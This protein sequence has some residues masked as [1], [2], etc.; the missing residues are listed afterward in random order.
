MNPFVVTAV[1]A[2][3]H[4]DAGPPPGDGP[5]DDGE[6]QAGADRGEHTSANGQSTSNGQS[7]RPGARPTFHYK[8]GWQERIPAEI[9]GHDQWVLWRYELDAKRRWTKVPYRAHQP[10]SKAST[11]DPQTWNPFEFAVNAFLE[12]QGTSNAFDGLG[13]VLAHGRGIAGFDLDKSLNEDGE[14]LPWAQEI[15]APLTPT[16]LDIS[17]SGRGLKGFVHAE[18]PGPGINRQ[19]Q[20]GPDAT[21]G[22]E[23]YAV[24]RFFTVT[25]DPYDTE[26]TTIEDR[27]GGV[28][29]LYQRFKPEPGTRDDRESSGPPLLSDDE[30]LRRARS[31]KNGADFSALF[32]DGR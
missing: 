21:G 10:T 9:R 4:P 6:G 23:L 25:G 28:V 32:D 11:T 8:D 22:F 17:P 13:Y 3:V 5:V 24:G 20:F 12:S 1:G 26:W 27:S 16:C 19:K 30:L 7:T 18:L 2:G 15:L 14:I 31:A 29:E